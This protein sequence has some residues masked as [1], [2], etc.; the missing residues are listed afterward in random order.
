[1]LRRNSSSGLQRGG[2]EPMVPFQNG[3]GSFLDA[4]CAPPGV[5]PPP[6]RL[7]CVVGLCLSAPTNCL[8]T[9]VQVPGAVVAIGEANMKRFPRNPRCVARTRARVASAALAQGQEHGHQHA[10]QQA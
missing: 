1:M 9:V 3:H 7:Y 4:G 5:L 6:L 2:L 8:R 10:I